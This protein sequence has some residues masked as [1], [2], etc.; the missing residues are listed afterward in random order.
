MDDQL[1]QLIDLQKEQNQLLKRYLWRF[2]FSLLG[3]L[4]LTTATAIGLGVLVY[5]TRPP[6]NSPWLAPVRIAI[7]PMSPPPPV[8]PVGD[9]N[10]RPAIPGQ[11]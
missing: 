6:K 5:Q 4:L 11:S 7:P 1:Q 8:A 10:L 9:I 2:R 3:L